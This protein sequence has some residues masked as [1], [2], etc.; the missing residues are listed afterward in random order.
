MQMI[1]G[2]CKCLNQIS[3]KITE[4]CMRLAQI[5][6][7]LSS[8]NVSRLSA[9]SNYLFLFSSY[10]SFNKELLSSEICLV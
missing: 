3:R 9:S 4:V 6:I 2:F 10:R 8:K 7:V 5:E 1:L